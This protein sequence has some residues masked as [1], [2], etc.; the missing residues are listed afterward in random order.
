MQPIAT[1]S[2]K[3]SQRKSILESDCKSPISQNAIPRR[4][5]PLIV[6]IRNMITADKNVAAAIPASSNVALSS[7][8]PRRPKK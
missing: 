3:Y 7:C 4:S 1:I 5:R 6:V 8:P 2:K